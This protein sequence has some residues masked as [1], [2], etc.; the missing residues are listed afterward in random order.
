M[1]FCREK[2]GLKH[3]E[4]D[5]RNRSG[6]F[7]YVSNLPS[8]GLY[9]ELKVGNLL[10]ACPW[11]Q[12][13]TGFDPTAHW[14]DEQCHFLSLSVLLYVLWS[15]II[16]VCTA[17]KWYKIL[18]KYMTFLNWSM[19][20]CLSIQLPLQFMHIIILHKFWTSYE[21]F[22]NYLKKLCVINIFIRFV[23]YGIKLIWTK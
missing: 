16:Y 6:L 2:D 14:T 19:L 1:V 23:V 9:S 21:H 13:K 18:L 17:A 11:K 20:F 15:H 22:S 3:I 4:S 12:D 10:P 7:L 8:T 5:K